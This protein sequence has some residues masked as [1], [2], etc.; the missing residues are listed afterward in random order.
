MF[1]YSIIDI[2][3][4][5]VSIILIVLVAL[6]NPKQELSDSL[7][8]GNSELFK[9]QKERGAE[10]VIVRLTYIFS[11]VFLVLGLFLFLK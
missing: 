1:E 9:N 4:I 5:V 10:A 7:S 3:F 6:Q 8:G 2:V 11:A